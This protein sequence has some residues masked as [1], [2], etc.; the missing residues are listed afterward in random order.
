MAKKVERPGQDFFG[1]PS[2]SSL[3]AKTL[4]WFHALQTDR[5]LNQPH[6]NLDGVWEM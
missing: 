3:S 1:L 6:S 2:F 4:E 5:M